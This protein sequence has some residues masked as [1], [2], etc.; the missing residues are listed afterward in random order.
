MK[1][2]RKEGR[3]EDTSGTHTVTPPPLKMA[4]MSSE[5]LKG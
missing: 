1:E 5:R 2:G 3:K 4:P